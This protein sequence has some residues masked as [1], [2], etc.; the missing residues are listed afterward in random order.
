MASC[1]LDRITCTGNPAV[2]SLPVIGMSVINRP[3]VL[4]RCLVFMLVFYAVCSLLLWEEVIHTI[5]FSLFM[6]MCMCVRACV[7]AAFDTLCSDGG[8]EVSRH[9]IG[10]V[11]GW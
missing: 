5:P 2:R 8:M 10:T 4:V 1:C 11:R 7:I 6:C 9:V 3:V